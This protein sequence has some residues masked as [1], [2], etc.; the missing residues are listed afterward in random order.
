MGVFNY[1]YHNSIKKYIEQNNK[2]DYISNEILTPYIIDNLSIHLRSFLCVATSLYETWPTTNH[3]LF[4]AAFIHFYSLQLFVTKLNNCVKNKEQVIYTSCKDKNDFLS[5][6]NSLLTIPIIL[7]TLI[8]SLFSTSY[9]NAI[10][11]CFVTVFM[12]FI[13]FV[14]P[15]YE[16]SHVA[17]HAGLLLETYF[18]SWCN[19]RRIQ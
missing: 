5:E 7:D 11:L 3:I 2:I 15:F 16:Y 18:L 1:K 17:F 19:L 4:F 9:I 6:I 10:N 14:Q 8:I 12:A 13:T